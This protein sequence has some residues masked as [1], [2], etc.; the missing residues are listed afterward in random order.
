MRSRLSRRDAEAFAAALD[1]RAP[2]R[3]KPDAN[4]LQEL[5]DVAD[6]VRATTTAPTANRD[7]VA[8]LRA[9]LMSAAT[10]ELAA[11][12]PPAR[13]DRVTVATPR[14]RRRLTAAASTFVVV[15]GSFGLVAASAQAVPGDMLYPVK[16]ATEKVE[17]MLRD[18]TAEGRILLDHALTRLG[19]VEALAADSGREVEDLIAETLSDFSADASAGGAL[20]LDAYRSSATPEEIEDLRAF[21]AESAQRLDSLA[22]VLPSSAATAYSD[23]ADTVNGLDSTAAQVCPTCAGGES[24][25]SVDG[26]LVAAVDEV[27]DSEQLPS[28]D[29]EPG[30]GSKPTN[31][32]P[33]AIPDLPNVEPGELDD[34]DGQSDGP[35]DNGQT[36]SDDSP[37]GD[38]TD[39]DDDPDT[40]GSGDDPDDDS[41]VPTPNDPVG[42]VVDPLTD[43][44]ESLLEGPLGLS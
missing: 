4:Q 1:G 24:A 27:L 21:A 5:V 30:A 31:R 36:P 43:V 25:I 28:G 40:G 10:E 17:L 35:G 26:E 37:S 14:I 20:L 15:G 38:D 9:E 2:G 22:G 34:P 29:A 32:G 6:F 23:A 8:G 7:F 11:P 12:T 41:P 3:H 19:E 18:G 44:V 33:N 16:R 13:S 39:S 42:D